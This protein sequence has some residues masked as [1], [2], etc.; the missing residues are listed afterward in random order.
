MPLM[1][2]TSPAD[3]RD[4]GTCTYAT[5]RYRLISLLASN[6]NGLCKVVGAKTW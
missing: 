1:V 4:I 5:I 6:T 3:C 2:L